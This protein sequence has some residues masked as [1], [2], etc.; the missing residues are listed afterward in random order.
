MAFNAIFGFIFMF[1]IIVGVSSFSF[2]YMQDSFV[3]RLELQQMSYDNIQL[4]KK[5]EFSNAFINSNRIKVEIKNIESNNL[6]LKDSSRKCFDV[7]VNNKFYPL[8]SVNFYTNNPSGNYF[9][10]RPGEKGF[11]EIKDSFDLNENLNIRLVSCN[12]ETFNFLFSNNRFSWFDKNYLQRTNFSFT[13][14]NIFNLIDGEFNLTL[15]SSNI[16]LLR[17]NKDDFNLIYP[18][19]QNLV[20]ELLFDENQQQLVDSSIFSQ[21]VYLGF[22]NL[23]ET[24]DPT[25]GQGTLFQSLSFD[26]INDITRIFY[27]QSLR[28]EEEIS[29]NMWVNWNQQGSS[30]Q[31]LFDGANNNY[32]SII[33]DGGM[34]QGRV[35]FSLNISNFQSNLISSNS[36]NPGW[37]FISATYDGNFK[38]IYINSQLVGEEIISGLISTSSQ[39]RYL[40]GF[41]SNNFF[42]GS[43]DKFRL[44]NIA[45]T[46]TEINS[47]YQGRIP[48]RN[49]QY[50]IE[51]NFLEGYNLT[52]EIPLIRPFE[53]AEIF[54]YY[55]NDDMVSILP[56]DLPTIP[57]IIP[58]I[59]LERLFPLS[60]QNVNFGEIFNISLNLTCVQ[61]SCNNMNLR[62]VFA[63]SLF[64]YNFTNCGQT[65]R[66]GPTQSQCDLEYES[67]SLAQNVLVDSGIQL[68][69]VPVSGNYQ[70][71]VIGAGFG[72]TT[73]Q[74]G[75]KMSG[76]F[77]L[78]QGQILKI[79]VGQ[80]GE[81][82]R[83]GSGGTFVTYQNNTPLIIA[84]GAGG[85]AEGSPGVSSIGGSIFQNGNNAVGFTAGTG[86]GGTGGSG[87]EQGGS[88]FAQSGSG[89]LGN[90][91]G[92]DGDVALSFV[93]GGIGASSATANSNGGFGGGGTGR[94]NSNWRIGGGGGYSGGASS[95]NN[96]DSYGGGGGSFNI[97]LNQDNQ[98][99]FNQGNGF[100]FITPLFEQEYE[101]I[102]QNLAEPFFT[103]NSNPS[104]ISLSNGNSQVINFS[105][106]PTSI[107]SNTYSFY[108]FVNLSSNLSINNK[109]SKYN[110]S[111][112]N[113]PQIEIQR[114]SPLSA[115]NVNSLDSFEIEVEVTCSGGTCRDVDVGFNIIPA[116]VFNFTNCGQTGRF[117]PTQF[118]CDSTYLGSSLQG[119]VTLNSGIQEWV[120]PQ[121]GFYFIE[122]YGAQGGTGARSGTGGLGAKMSGEFYLEAG[123]TLKILVGQ[124]GT[125]NANMVGGGG[126]S[127]VT[128]LNNSP[129]IIAGG[130]GGYGVGTTTINQNVAHAT[131][132]TQA[133]SGVGGNSFGIGGNDGQGGTG[134][135]S[136]GQGGSGLLTNG[137]NVNG[138][139]AFIN[140]GLG[141]NGGTNANGGFGGGGSVDQNTGWGA[142]AG[143]GG[144]SGGG[145]AYSSGNDNEA[146]GGGGASF[147]LGFNQ[148][149]LEAV[150][151]GHGFVTI[152]PLLGAGL[153]PQ[154]SGDFFYTLENNP[155]RVF[156]S[157]GESQIISLNVIASGSNTEFNFYE[158]A[159]L[160]IQPQIN[161]IS[162]TST[163]VSIN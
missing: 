152:T 151:S 76:E 7:Y 149:N 73:F 57:T 39:D 80:I 59:S 31:I 24:N 122:T 117:G 135:N 142:A 90:G 92:C 14:S 106:I 35:S 77:Y 18:I 88:C 126:G 15:N 29:I 150:N 105:I 127:F 26:G 25:F 116:N 6:I 100:V 52:F 5:L 145:G 23:V 28:L 162:S 91:V 42:N 102:P 84:G 33:N 78:E 120:V 36:L 10:L 34:N 139:I 4:L 156:L 82:P 160:V 60:N 87:G 153:I 130:G 8:D 64:F 161:N 107:N 55:Y 56:E 108:E 79:L 58:Q 63:E 30:E 89:F 49:L 69:E 129:F 154:G 38:R 71:D 37:N 104:L 32:L 47:L 67:T 65:G 96:F 46:Q 155:Q 72:E 113:I 20:L 22:S 16:N 45:L 133:N 19:N 51:D 103:L 66:F 148:D 2:V 44:Y 48:K 40:G 12:G 86:L 83:A 99:N 21:N 147:N 118:Q 3:Q 111:I 85:Q 61:G 112:Q 119:Q 124:M 93:N 114:I 134:A 110:V 121:S 125:S 146:A 158:D 41:P 17:F 157:N 137:Q 141:G 74:R 95:G 140:G 123:Q 1:I 9:V 159:T 54:I 68:W 98:P 143:G 136:R 70:I 13:N 43:I 163:L 27:S 50:L 81:N 97:G 138:G 109:T 11:I 75:A 115:L 101:L 62:S 128:F 53:Q 94:A 144:Y 132:T 131:I